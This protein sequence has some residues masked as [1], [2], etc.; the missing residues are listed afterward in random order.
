MAVP[1]LP[2]GFFRMIVFLQ[3]VDDSHNTI[4]QPAIFSFNLNLFSFYARDHTYI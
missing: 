4:F 3:N 2:P 1:E